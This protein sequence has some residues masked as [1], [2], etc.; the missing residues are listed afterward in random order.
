MAL[1]YFLENLFGRKVELVTRQSL[2]PY[3]GPH[4]L[5]TVE[6]VPIAGRI[7]TSHS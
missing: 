1:A 2:S 5:K 4:I 3:L 7:P 6:Y